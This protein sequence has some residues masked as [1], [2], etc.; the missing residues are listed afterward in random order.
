MEHKY[1]SKNKTE[2]TRNKR[3][4]TY[5]E[6]NPVDKLGL[7]K[8]DETGIILIYRQNDKFKINSNEYL[9]FRKEIKDIYFG[10][11][12]EINKYL[13]ERISDYKYKLNVINAFNKE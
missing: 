5:N 12:Y 4:K 7:I 8:I 11:Q 9:A 13:D 3:L 10:S 1:Y 2:I 6:L